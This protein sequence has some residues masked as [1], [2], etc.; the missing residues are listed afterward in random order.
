VKRGFVYKTGPAQTSFE[1]VIRNNAPGGGGNDWAIDDIVVASCLPIMTY[2]PSLLPTVCDSNSLRIYDTVRSNYENYTYYKWQRST[3][4]GANWTDITGN[5]GP[6]TPSWNG[7]AWEYIAHYDIPPANTQAADSGDLYRMIVATTSGN[8]SS[9]SCQAT[10]VVSI[11]TLDI[12]DCGVL[13]NVDFINFNGKLVN[14]HS[15]LSWSTTTE[16]EPVHFDVERSTDGINF[17]RIGSVNGYN[18]S[19]SPVNYYSFIDP[20]AVTGKVWYRIVMV[21]KNASTKQT[22]T[23]QLSKTQNQFGLVSLINPF[24]NKVE[25]DITTPANGQIDVSLIDM[26][27]NVVREKSFSVYTGVNGLSLEN[28]GALPSGVYILQIK[29]K[30]TIISRKVV[31]KN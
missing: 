22:R 27:G 9:P 14:D 17:Y 29:N 13:L 26:V 18:D 31:K 30:E 7:S 20:E 10:D 24:N 16:N 4:G 2:S 23:I 12:I 6:A 15:N 5:L 11:V 1:F 8:L 28:T 3:D 19:R 21:N 25:F